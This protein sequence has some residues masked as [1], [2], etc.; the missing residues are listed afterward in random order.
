MP[1]NT[2]PEQHAIICVM[3]KLGYTNDD[4][5][6]NLPNRHDITNHGQLHLQGLTMKLVTPQAALAS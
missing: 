2:T 1:Q 5:R 6:A 3:K 4:V